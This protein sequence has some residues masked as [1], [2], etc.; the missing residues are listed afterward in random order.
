VSKSWRV[1]LVR[2]AV[3]AALVFV[4]PVL[5]AAYTL[6]FYDGRRIEIPA[7]YT[8]TRTT[9]TYE[10]APGMFVT[11][12]LSLIDVAATERVNQQPL[13]ALTTLT[14]APPTEAP[15]VKITPSNSNRLTITNASLEPARQA[16][17]KSE[18]AYEQRRRE[19]GLPTVAETRRR[20]L[21]LSAETLEISRER[22]AQEESDEAQ[23]RGRAS[24]LRAELYDVN[25][26][27]DFLQARVA[28]LPS[29]SASPSILG[30]VVS[31]YPIG[32]TGPFGQ[33]GPYGQTGPYGQ[34]GGTNYP[35]RQRTYSAPGY[36]DNR[37]GGSRASNRGDRSGRYGR[38]P[39]GF[40][41]GRYGYGYPGAPT[42]YGYPGSPTGYGYPGYPTGYG[43]PGYGYPGLPTGY[44]YPGYPTANGYPDVFG[45]QPYGVADS[46]DAE[47]LRAQLNDLLSTRAGLQARWRSL[48]EDARR[49]GVPPGWLRP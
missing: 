23:W 31:S 44:G 7:N 22:R 11:L 18:V 6:V 12:Q 13:G 10:R 17:L 47:Q 2:A 37:S 19:L 38:N 26:R 16:R 42:G 36:R 34:I 45:T 4:L 46:Y 21:A 40:G 3:T 29:S 28:E 49:A 30:G 1:R 33:V 25:A 8:V 15:E 41:I 5:T 24:D 14:A 43:Y 32:Q 35:Y 9:L 27:I 20:E 48:E 39:N